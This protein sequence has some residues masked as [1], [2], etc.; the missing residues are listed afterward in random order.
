[1]TDNLEL[2]NFIHT[3][4][5]MGKT[6]INQLLGVVKGGDFATVLE[7]QVNEYTQIY[8]VAQNEISAAQQ[9]PEKVSPLT[10]ASTY[11]MINMNTLTNKTPSH[12]SEMLIQGSTMGTIDITKRMNQYKGSDQK[13]KDLASRLLS[14]T[15]DSF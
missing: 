5:E 10:K 9:K 4:A 13:V 14:R 2:L 6:T 7:S 3:N 12:I 8:D 11:L 15:L 1:M